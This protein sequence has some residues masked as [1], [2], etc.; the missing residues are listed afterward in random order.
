MTLTNAERLTLIKTLLR[1][2]GDFQD[3][4][5]M[6][7]IDEAIDFMIAAGVPDKIAR[8]KKAIGAIAMYVTD[9][10][11]YAQGAIKYSDALQKRIIQLAATSEV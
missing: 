2:G 6:A 1:V 8:S 7:Q 10:D 11:N 3:N 9:T 5:L 4:V